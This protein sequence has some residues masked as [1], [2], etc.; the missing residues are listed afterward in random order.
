MLYDHVYDYGLGCK[1]VCEIA[2]ADFSVKGRHLKEKITFDVNCS[3][4]EFDGNDGLENY[5]S[6]ITKAVYAVLFIGDGKNG[7][8]AALPVMCS[9]KNIVSN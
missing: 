6:W 9:G 3:L 2:S 1:Y 4:P 8:S 5:S 7:H